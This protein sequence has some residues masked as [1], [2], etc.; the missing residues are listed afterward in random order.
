MHHHSSSLLANHAVNHICLRVLLPQPQC[1][2]SN[3]DF[4]MT[5][6]AWPIPTLSLFARAF[7][8]YK[9]PLIR[10]A[11]KGLGSGFRALN[12]SAILFYIFSLSNE[13]VTYTQ[14]TEKY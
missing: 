4:M 3:I 5:K 9:S 13:T 2:L 11:T 7:Q 6:L 8:E 12:P 1:Q 14:E 10:A